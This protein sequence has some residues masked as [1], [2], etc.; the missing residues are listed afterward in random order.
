MPNPESELIARFE[1]NGRR[2]RVIGMV[3][4]IWGIV[5]S[6]TVLID[7]AGWIALTLALFTLPALWDWFSNRRSNLEIHSNRVSWQSGR[8]E[9][10]VPIQHIDHMRID[11]RIDGGFR[12]SIAPTDR[13]PIRLPPDIPADPSRLEPA[14]K[15]AG[16]AFQR[17][18]FS[19]LQW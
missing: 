10:T 11:R 13:R 3:L 5:L 12:L 7:L 16:I 14:L 2:R 8:Q 6:L 17:H 9:G 4:G 19:L 1:T 18:P 15:E